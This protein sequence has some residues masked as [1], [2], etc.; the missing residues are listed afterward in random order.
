[1]STHPI[2]P[3][4]DPLGQNWVQPERSRI[5]IDER[6]ARMDRATFDRLPEY[7][8]TRPTGVY[9]GKMWKRHDGAFDHKFLREG[10]KPVWLLCWY[11]ESD[12]PGYCSNHHREI[13]IEA[14][15]PSG[16]AGSTDEADSERSANR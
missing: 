13:L 4:T 14:V 7:S 15:E 12:K 1:V 16:N 5:H 9:P 6:Y 3:I 10:G 8:A 11:G 2:P